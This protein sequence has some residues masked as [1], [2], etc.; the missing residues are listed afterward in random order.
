ME[1][2]KA[3]GNRNMVNKAGAKQTQRR[4]TKAVFFLGSAYHSRQPLALAAICV[5]LCPPPTGWSGIPDD[6]PYY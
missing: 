2:V 1:S 4:Q 6:P 3:G 5:M